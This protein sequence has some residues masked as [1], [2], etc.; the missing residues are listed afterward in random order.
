MLD[1]VRDKLASHGGAV[2]VEYIIII[3]LIGLAVIAGATV[4][5][6]AINNELSEAS[7]EVDSSLVP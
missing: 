5:G 4:L 3:V 2:S 1:K 6:Q 7:T